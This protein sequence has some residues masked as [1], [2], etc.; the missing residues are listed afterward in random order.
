MPYA[1]AVMY[2]ICTSGHF[3]LLVSRRTMATVERHCM[4]ST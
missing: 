3:Q 4:A 1:S 2:A